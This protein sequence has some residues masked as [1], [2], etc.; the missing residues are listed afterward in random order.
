MELYDLVPNTTYDIKI[1]ARN[2]IG[3]SP[4]VFGSF[5]TGSVPPKNIS[6][7]TFTQDS[8]G[9]YA[10]VLG[11]GLVGVDNAYEYSEALSRSLVTLN[12]S[13]MK[14]CANGL[15]SLYESYGVNPDLFSDTAPCYKLFDPV[16][17]DILINEERAVIRLADDFDV[18]SQGTVSVNG[19]NTF[20]FNQQTTNPGG[21]EE[22]AEPTAIVNNK[23]LEGKPTINK[24][25]TFSGTAE[26]GAVVTVTVRSDPIICSATADSNGNWSCTLPGDL[27]AGDHTVTVNV[28]NPDGSTEQLGPYAVVVPAGA[29]GPTTVSNTTPFA[30]NT[31][32]ERS[33]SAAAGGVFLAIGGIFSIIVLCFAGIRSLRSR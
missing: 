31:G 17:S 2:S 6:S 15:A 9:R 27:P 32:F 22:P 19:S 26:P 8:D 28:T 29:A 21:N 30:P 1:A 5:K 12:G 7:V 3:N 20:T 16:T 14:F 33:V 25:P 4:E 10:T 24:R 23:P 18:T 11:T 13:P